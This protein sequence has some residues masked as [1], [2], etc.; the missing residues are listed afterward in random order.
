MLR[1]LRV[2]SKG[3]FLGWPVR[4]VRTADR[5]RGRNLLLADRLH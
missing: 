3:G 2:P 4:A 1:A 5:T